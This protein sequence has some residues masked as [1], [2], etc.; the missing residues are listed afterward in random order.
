MDPNMEL[1][2][3]KLHQKKH[4]AKKKKKKKSGFVHMEKCKVCWQRKKT[5]GIENGAQKKHLK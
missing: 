1:K 3:R 4:F 2:E 5:M